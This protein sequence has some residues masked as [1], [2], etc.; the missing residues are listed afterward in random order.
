MCITETFYKLLDDLLTDSDNSKY[1]EDFISAINY[2]SNLNLG[3]G[4]FVSNDLSFFKLFPITRLDNSNR[5]SEYFNKYQRNLLPE[6]F[7]DPD[8]I[9]IIKIY[10]PKGF[11][12]IWN[13]S[14][15]L[16]EQLPISVLL[17]IIYLEL[18][19]T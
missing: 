10:L 18:N 5:N 19:N 17:S 14:I 8:I 9:R 16:A 7:D 4:A 3:S 6:K 13:K 1:F 12:L 11:P 15:G 2:M